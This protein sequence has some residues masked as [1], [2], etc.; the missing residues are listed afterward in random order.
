MSTTAM[1]F[2]QLNFKLAEALSEMQNDTFW[3]EVVKFHGGGVKLQH[4]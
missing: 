4:V 2:D 3:V 1:V